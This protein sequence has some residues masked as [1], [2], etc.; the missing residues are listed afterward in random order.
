MIYSLN[1]YTII[2]R[3]FN[4]PIIRPISNIGNLFIGLPMFYFIKGLSAI[5]I[6]AKPCSDS[7]LLFFG[8]AIAL[9]HIL[10]VCGFNITKQF[11]KTLHGLNRKGIV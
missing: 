2:Y 7:L 9:H 10:D 4:F 6:V 11:A 1:F 5:R 8:F 3:A